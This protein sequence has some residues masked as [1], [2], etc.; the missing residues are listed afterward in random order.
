MLI[1]NWIQYS[2]RKQVKLEGISYESELIAQWLKSDAS[3]HCHAE[4]LIHAFSHNAGG[5][6]DMAQ[7][8]CSDRSIFD[9]MDTF[10]EECRAHEAIR[11]N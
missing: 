4:K 11:R 3:R 1:A 5:A 10:W 8:R 7:K 6:L 2:H 9:R